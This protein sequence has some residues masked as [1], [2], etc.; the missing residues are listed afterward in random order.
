MTTKVYELTKYSETEFELIVAGQHFRKDAKVFIGHGR[1][2]VPVYH[3]N[4]KGTKL[5]CHVPVEFL[6]GL[7]IGKK[8]LVV[9]VV[10]G[11]EYTFGRGFFSTFLK[12]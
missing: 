5:W 8:E 2:E 9:V 12:E 4:E 3:I 1:D 11:C 6:E 7:E 10:D